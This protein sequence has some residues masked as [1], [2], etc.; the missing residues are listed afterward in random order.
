M[1]NQR[2]WERSEAMKW[3]FCALVWGTSSSFDWPWQSLRSAK[4]TNPSHTCSVVTV[5]PKAQSPRGAVSEIVWLYI[6][7]QF[8][9]DVLQTEIVETD[10]HNKIWKQT[11]TMTLTW[12]WSRAVW[13]TSQQIDA[14]PLEWHQEFHRNKCGCHHGLRSYDDS[15]C[16]ILFKLVR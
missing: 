2:L 7:A 11:C 12:A 4:S 1:W 5:N 6:R 16:C 9:A 14:H 8:V 13:A 15:L 10:F 3:S